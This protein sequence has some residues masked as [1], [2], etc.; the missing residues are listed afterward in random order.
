MLCWQ[1][2][3]GNYREFLQPAIPLPAYQLEG[4]ATAAAPQHAVPSC[5]C[6]LGRVPASLSAGNPR[7]CQQQALH[8]VSALTSPHQ[9]ANIEVAVQVHHAYILQHRHVNQPHRLRSAD[10][11]ILLL[12]L[13]DRACRA[14]STVRRSSLWLCCCPA[15][16]STTRLAPL[17]PSLLSAWQWF[18]A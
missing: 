6:V 4:A 2:A 11:A 3:A 13:L 14:S 5:S 1:Q 17:M 10:V 8:A 15:S 7:L 12:L 9:Q 18:A 16:S